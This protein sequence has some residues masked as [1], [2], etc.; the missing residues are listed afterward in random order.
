MSRLI[1]CLNKRTRQQPAGRFI[2]AGMACLVL[3]LFG[4][5]AFGLAAAEASNE[6]INNIRELTSFGDR[7][8]AASG[9]REAAAYIKN[10]LS[11]LSIST[12]ASHRFSVPVMSHGIGRLK[13]GG[14]NR[15]VA[16][17]PFFGNAVTPQTIPAPGIKGPLIYAG[18]GEP[19]EFNG[20][21]IR[22]AVVLMELNSG[23]NWLHAAD[24]GARAVIYVDRE[25]ASRLF[26]EDKF[27]LSPIQFPRFWMPAAEAY[28]LFGE[29]DQAGG[30]RV[31][32][33]VELTADTHWQRTV[34]E[35]IY[36][37]IPGTDAA[38]QRELIIVEAFYDSSAY[39]AGLS[40][41][42]DEACGIAT[43]LDFARA[44]T[45]RPPKRTVL[46]IASAGHSQ[47]LSGMREM[48]WSLTARAKELKRMEEA[49]ES[50]V[51]ESRDALDGLEKAGFGLNPGNTI[52]NQKS[53]ELAISAVKE[54][55]KTASDRLS[56]RLM[57]LRLSDAKKAD[58]VVI[59]QLAHQRQVLQRLIWR[60][61][62]DSVGMSSD[63][64]RALKQAIPQAVADQ[65]AVLSD[66]ELEL[67]LLG[68]AKAFRTKVQ[69]YDV[70]AFISLHLSSHGD[71][72]GA[73]NYGWLYPF[74][75][76]INRLP[77]YTALSDALVR[78]EQAAEGS[79]GISGLFHDTL[80]PSRLSSW[81]SYFVDRP[82]LGGEVSALAGY[83]G[84]TL[85]TTHDARAVW[86]TPQDTLE[87]IDAGF[88][89]RQSRVV[90]EVL[91]HLAQDT[92]LYQ[93]QSPRDGFSTLTGRAKFLRHGELFADQPAPGTVLLAYQGPA[94]FYAMVDSRGMFSLRG[95]ADSKHSFYKVILEGYKF[96]EQDGS[97]MWTIDK[98]ETGLD[99]Y[100]VKM[101]RQAMET[102]LVMFAGKG[103][104]LFNLLEPRS[105]Q[106]LTRINVIDGRR[107]SEPLHYFYSRLDTRS[108]TIG[109]IFLEPGTPLKLTLSDSLLS[110]KMILL[111]GSRKNPQGSGYRVDQWPYIHRTAYRVAQD[112][113]TL[114]EPRI[115]N[116]EQRGIYNARLHDLFKAGSAALQNAE[117]AYK[118]RSYQL[119]YESS[120]KAWAL[121][122]RVY[123]DVE[124]TQKDVL[125][126][127]L[128]YIAL[129]VPFAFCMERLLFSFSNIYKRIVAFSLI[130]LLLIAV[131][132]QV[133]PAFQLA[134]SPIVVILA[135]LIMGLALL[136]TLIVFFRF[137]AEI[138]RLQVRAKRASSNE[139]GRWKAFVAAFL[140]GVSNLRRRRL[141]TALTCIT[142]I[143]LTFTIM[144]F[145]SAKSI[146][147]HTRILFSD[148]SP[149]LGF[150][151]KKANW[152]SMPAEALGIVVNA[153]QGSGTAAPR[154]WLEGVD[155]TRP[156]PIPLQ[157]G[158]RSFEAMGLV[159]M[160]AN[161]AAVTGIDAT[162]LAGRWMAANEDRVI[163]IP[164]RMARTLGIS[165]KN[166]GGHFVTLWGMPFEVI[167]VFS[168]EKLQAHMDLDGEIPTPVTFPSELSAEMSEE[169]VTAME[170]GEDVR[171]FQSR[172]QHIS[173]ELTVIIPFRTLL[174]A[175]GAL[176][177]IAI[178]PDDT[179]VLRSDGS[180]LADRF[181]LS[182]FSGE[183]NGTYLYHASNTMQY[184]GIPNIIV[185]IVLSI[186]I[187]LNTMISSVYERKREIGV[188]TSI[189]LA[190][191]HV[192][193]LFIA[194]AM[195]FAVLS[196][197]IGYL[198]AQTTAK[199]FSNTALWSG[200]T[201][202]YSS[203]A[204]VG[205]MMLVILVVM[206]SVIYPSKVAGEIAIPD[207]NR[208]W[209]L[210][211]PQENTLEVTLPFLM[212]YA[213]HGSVG[214]Y[215]FEYL[216]SH[217]D[218]THGKFSTADIL[219][220]FA[221]ATPPSLL[222]NRSDCLMEDTC[223]QEECLYL[224][225]QVWLAPF[226]FG[227]TQKVTLRFVPS[228]EEPGLLE[229]RMMLIRDSGEANAWLRINK[230]FLLE[231]RKQLLMWRSLDDA[232][233]R[234][235]EG[236]LSEARRRVSE[237]R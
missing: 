19:I 179:T 58:P 215:L 165:I 46:L 43:L 17:R 60:K 16:L 237:A 85:V 76:R 55:I 124:K 149:Y 89:K 101:R 77:N 75:P 210:P 53:E 133:H 3:F 135:F 230:T 34:A 127:V 59:E 42:A 115:K 177:S 138:T 144:S 214:G 52:T 229:I 212:T 79:T 141:R 97:A 173:G 201:V 48:L 22:G 2:I 123:D 234:H 95:V 162:L 116:L 54:S 228:M 181:S 167:G 18:T 30:N 90:T 209:S 15:T 91:H 225:S 163:L 145:T 159:G 39:V 222:S 118:A 47:S 70:L 13:I 194:E 119:F 28:A 189:G 211:A 227:I 1:I 98:N 142:L 29:F 217:Q 150:L 114:I 216:E 185:P 12:I 198:L 99:A 199:L 219:F 174:A 134:Y 45:L 78:A 137:E 157:H 125:Y 20:N 120:D 38:L 188:Y 186:L 87:K 68:S 50:A 170:S 166:P 106:Y 231:I 72:V 102:D 86:G 130:L 4:Q 82:P 113:W 180:A 158:D 218:I 143:I 56:R 160:S 21:D 37:V 11:S 168:G 14:S 7:H 40:P 41:G 51:A 61:S 66:A 207:V 108:S 63:E 73:F 197:V 110:K 33:H 129:F 154:V 69:E 23:K 94:R 221:C 27:E 200:I 111:N 205:A 132:Y 57:Q 140:L 92:D 122:N 226:D 204:G 164:D 187:V 104:T 195:A 156:T 206:V 25:D 35:N 100:R 117:K 105:F 235:Y 169:E 171:E 103:T 88:A 10:Q 196:V 24:L 65:R 74:R 153:F 9:S 64:R 6:F 147:R 233:K 178:R 176:K 109:T 49:L 161:E 31:A 84:L 32:K 83:H 224:A 146:R 213:E 36:C 67:E 93:A 232:G 5:Q 148:T 172:Y 183:R 139:I 155:K 192:S 80:R 107:E 220:T 236:V 44:L 193:F 96:S 131:I 121:A 62:F 112:M 208:S 152:R 8:T 223:D 175:G 182:I 136:V 71:G 191:S 81:Q 128:F 190:P 203:M 151:L 202:N 126:G 26:F 184:S